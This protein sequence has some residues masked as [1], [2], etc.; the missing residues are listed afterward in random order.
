MRVEKYTSLLGTVT[1]DM[2]GYVVDGT[3]W[4]TPGDYKEH[5]TGECARHAETGA[6]RHRAD[7]RE[8]APPAD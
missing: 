1:M 8:R 6:H 5:C 3:H 2:T 4:F 7:R